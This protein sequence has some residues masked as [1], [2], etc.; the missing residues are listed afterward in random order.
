MFK[1]LAA[2]MW[3]IYLEI[4]ENFF[5]TLLNHPDSSHAEFYQLGF[6][7]R[8]DFSSDF[9]RLNSDLAVR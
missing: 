5:L 8:D 4:P 3:L 2:S 6:M 9:G 1:I 7:S